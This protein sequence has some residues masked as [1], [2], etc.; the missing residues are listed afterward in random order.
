MGKPSN[1]KGKE[2]GGIVGVPQ[3]KTEITDKMF[4][5]LAAGKGVLSI[6]S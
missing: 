6:V 5:D 4:D 1:V 2:I 3:D